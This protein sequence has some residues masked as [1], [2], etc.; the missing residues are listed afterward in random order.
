APPREPARALYYLGIC[1]LKQHLSAD[2]AHAFA[3][4]AQRGDA[5]DTGAAAAI[6][7][8]EL[9]LAEADPAPA[10]DTL[11]RVVRDFKEPGDWH[12][13]LVDLDRVRE[14][15][16]MG[17]EKLR[18]DGRF[19]LAMRLAALYEPLAAEGSGQLQLGRAAFEWGQRTLKTRPEEARG[20][21][22]LAGE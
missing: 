20:R 2:A 7:L 22:H 12:N 10:L 9:Q 16:E 19:E 11:E 13:P 6:G 4:C 3:E 15:L 17:C 1:Y 18:K 5:G 8:A 14:V 21:F